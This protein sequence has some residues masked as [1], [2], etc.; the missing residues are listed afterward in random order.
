MHEKNHLAPI[1]IFAYNRPEHLI[2]ALDALSKNAE[3][4]ISNLFIFIDGPKNSSHNDAVRSVKN[5]SHSAKGFFAVN[6]ISREV[7]L[8]LSRSV[9]DGVSEV[10]RSF[11]RV[12]ILE[13]DLVVSPYFLRYMNDALDLYSDDEV[14]ASIHG[15][16]Y[17]IEPFE[18]QTF[19]LRGADCWG[20][21]TWR[22]AWQHFKPDGRSLLRQLRSAGLLHSFDLYG[23]YPF[24]RMLYR[25]IQGKNDSWAIRWHA[26]TFLRGMLTLYPSQS[27]VENIGHDNSGTHTALDSSFDVEVFTGPVILRQIPLAE[28][29]DFRNA[30]RV[31]F[32]LTRGWSTYLLNTLFEAWV[33]VAPLSWLGI[34]P[35]K[36]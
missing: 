8:G 27:L 20:W 19:F 17:P 7:N 2:N 36:T 22:R 9:I 16:N 11:D 32:F 23:A 26:S 18:Q 29:L 14:V 35:D 31:Y 30:I 24:S 4:S 15:Y 21:G 5:I 28:S 6:V 1:V 33:R 3:A 12:I 10:L 25:Q 34:Q 13:D